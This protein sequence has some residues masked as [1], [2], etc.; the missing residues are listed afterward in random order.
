MPD[1]VQN[2]NEANRQ[3]TFVHDASPSLPKFDGENIPVHAFLRDTEDEM[4]RRNI[5]TDKEKIALL[6]SRINLGDCLAG[7]IIQSDLFQSFHEYT[8][9]R[10]EFLFQFSGIDKVGSLAPLYKFAQT[11]HA[12]TPDYSISQAIKSSS[13]FKTEFMQQMEH[14]AWVDNGKISLENCVNLFGYFHFLTVLPSNVAKDADKH[15]FAPGQTI[16]EFAR[17]FKDKCSKISPVASV[18]YS[19][20]RG[21][22]RQRMQPDGSR[23]RSASG[24]L[25]HPHPPPTSQSPTR[26]QDQPLHH[27]SH[28]PSASYQRGRSPSHARQQ[29][30]CSYCKKS[31]HT[32]K[33][34]YT[35]PSEAYSQRHPYWCDHHGYCQHETTDCRYLNNSA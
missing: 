29:Y 8:A 28:H 11:M 20:D 35:R 32:I 31:G 24:A 30:Y 1:A 2:Q 6:K 18:S 3:I 5:T 26:T 7:D 16:T 17:N 13:Q 22:P 21:R 25:N 27:S 10:K 33:Y 14:S 34:C 15:E 23:Q 19:Q 9:F 4:I 12:E